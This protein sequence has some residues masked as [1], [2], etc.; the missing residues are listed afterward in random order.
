MNHE[1]IEI[2]AKGAYQ[3]EGKD[4]FRPMMDTY[5]LKGHTF[6]DN[7]VPVEHSLLFAK[8]MRRKNI[9]FELH[10][11]PEGPHG[12]SL[13]TD[14]TDEEGFGMN[15]HVATWMGLCTEWLKRLFF[16]KR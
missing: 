4:D 5:V 9:P 15:L 3:S 10:I 8:A 13:A 16:D 6:N 11:Y 2:W 1:T 7:I 12:L 14:E